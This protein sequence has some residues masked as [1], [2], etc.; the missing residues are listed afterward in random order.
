MNNLLK[1]FSLYV[2]LAVEARDL[3][4]GASNR[5][6]TGVEEKVEQMENIKITTISIRDQAG[7]QSMGRPIGDYITIESPPLK[8][9]DP[10]IK[11]EIIQAMDKAMKILIKDFLKPGDTVLLVGLGN[12]RATADSL[13]P[14]FIEYSPISRHYHQHAP[15]ALV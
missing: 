10:Y 7:A 13:G 14:K 3:V 11:E 15:E 4:R 6:I 5:E 12:W 8:T 9:Y 1:E 2:D